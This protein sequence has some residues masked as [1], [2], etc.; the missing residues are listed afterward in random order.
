MASQALGQDGRPLP[1]VVLPAFEG[2]LDLL[3][4]LVR[5]NK[6]SVW[7]IP[8]AKICDQYQAVLRRMEV[9]DLEIG[10]EYLLLAAWLLAIKSRLLLPRVEKDA[11]P[12]QELVERLLEYERVR[13]AAAELAGLDEIR[14]G[15]LAVKVAHPELANDDAIDLA[16][17]DVLMLAA[18]LRN[19][20]ER[21]RHEH[22]A[23]IEVAPIRFSVREKIAEL[24]ELV[25]RQHS[26][27]FLSHLL[28]RTDRIESATLL[29]AALELVRLGNIELHQR[30]PF[31]EIYLTPTSKPLDAGELSD[32]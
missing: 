25:S 23:P 4:H 8:I 18:A 30:V 20:L 22:P 15:V 28:T 6:V 16:E 32:A 27:A 24:Y 3:L 26:F 1:A 29:V 5:E 31:A 11:D 2:P 17:V 14:R 13:A 7:D 10:G 12:R 19:A 9:L 21:H